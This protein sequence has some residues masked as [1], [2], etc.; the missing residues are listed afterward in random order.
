M[1]NYNYPLGADKDG[2]PWRDS[3]KRELNFY[4]TISTS[5]SKNCEVCTND[6]NVEEDV[7]EGM[8]Y[9]FISTSDTDWYEVYAKNIHYTPL[10]LINKF[11][12]FLTKHIPDPV[13]D[14]A[15]YKQYKHL[16]NECTDWIED[17]L[18]IIKE[19]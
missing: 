16:I 14:I 12:E 3:D 18:V 9:N 7:D 13:V 17:E 1:D 15:G 2:A 11:K 8:R 19:E 10:E 6:Y 4:V 5:L